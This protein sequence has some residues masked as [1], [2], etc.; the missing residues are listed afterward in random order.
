MQLEN[1]PLRFTDDLTQE[2]SDECVRTWMNRTV[3]RNAVVSERKAL[4]Q[5]V[6]K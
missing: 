5:R 2:D 6:G 3:A 1:T 4:T